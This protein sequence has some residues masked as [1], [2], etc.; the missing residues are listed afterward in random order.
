MVMYHG[1]SVEEGPVED[2]L[3]HPRDPY[4]RRLLASYNEAVLR[5]AGPEA[6]PA[7]WSAVVLKAVGAEQP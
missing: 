3:S 2:I 7:L 4:T 6:K 5:S 1:R